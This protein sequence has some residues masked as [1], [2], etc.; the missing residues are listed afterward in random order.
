MTANY[1]SLL[2]QGA[3]A[4]DSVLGEKIKIEPR[5]INQYSGSQVDGTRITFEIIAVLRIDSGS[6][7]SLS[8][9]RKKMNVSIGSGETMV[10]IDR[11]KLPFDIKINAGDRIIALD[12]DGSPSFEVERVDS[13]N[14]ARLEL[15]LCAVGNNNA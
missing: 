10:F 8:G 12:R 1:Q 2:N 13:R 4:V 14:H 9:S 7:E 15:S 11:E 5:A 6:V 3:A